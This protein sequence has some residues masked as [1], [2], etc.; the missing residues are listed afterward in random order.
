MI[1]E[2]D[3]FKKAKFLYENQKEPLTNEVKKTKI[4]IKNSGVYKFE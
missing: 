1:E 3:N 2:V 4:F